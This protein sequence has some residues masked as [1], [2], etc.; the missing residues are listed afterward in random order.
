MR[1][2]LHGPV[3]HA[4][5]TLPAG[6]HNASREDL[7]QAAKEAG[8]ASVDLL[9]EPVAAGIAF[10]RSRH[11]L[12]PEGAMLVLDWG[13]GT[14]DLAV[15]TTKDGQPRVVADL[16]AGEEGLGGED[17][18]SHLLRLVDQRLLQLKLSGLRRR[19]QE[20]TEAVRRRVIEWK[21]THSGKPGAVWSMHDCLTEV[22]ADA[23]LSWTSETIAEHLQEKLKLAADACERL[24]EKARAKA[25]SPTGLL[26]IG[27]SSQFPAFRAMLEKR[28]PD[29]T[30]LK[31]E[32]R[33]T[34]VAEGATW[35]AA[36][37]MGQ[38]ETT[39]SL[40]D[41]T[42]FTFAANNPLGMNFVRVPILDGQKVINAVFFGEYPVRVKDYEAFVKETGRAWSRPT[43]PQTGDH[44]AVNV[45]WHDAK[46]FCDWL[47]KKAKRQGLGVVY[48]LP[49]DHKWSCAA[50]LGSIESAND[51]ADKKSQSP[52]TTGKFVWGD[53]WPPPFGTFKPEF[54]DHGI[55]PSDAFKKALYKSWDYDDDEKVQ[56]IMSFVGTWAFFGLASLGF[57]KAKDA[58]LLGGLHKFF[59]SMSML[60]GVGLAILFVCRCGVFIARVREYYTPRLPKRT[61][62][63][64]Q[65]PNPH[66]NTSP[67]G[68]Q[69]ATHQLYELSGNVWEWVED[70][71]PASA[72]ERI[73]RGGAWTEYEPERIRASFREHRLS[74]T[75][76]D[77]IGFRCVMERV[78]S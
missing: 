54:V 23:D 8:F 6:W 40:E 46:A 66:P 43:F 9:E 33:L 69:Q 56:L 44:P 64:Q 34:A 29:L 37:R 59:A 22:P 47:T 55:S 60:A 76:A 36:A 28:F 32:R 31:W 41:N 68:S 21:I 62:G 65:Y 35:H 51:G 4:V 5:I 50:G 26:L 15:L 71:W 13:A 24:L 7:L 78:T 10:M 75:L 17:L 73:L 25:I 19:K 70:A 72:Q 16:V 39:A 11:E 74:E 1:A 20:E 57:Q 38:T 58:W 45:H 63:I 30:L 53:Y 3:D 49:S 77:D 18:D 27:G 52:K 48:R 2:T 14:L 67:V 42:T 12:W 61:P